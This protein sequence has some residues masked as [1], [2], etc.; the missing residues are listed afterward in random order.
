MKFGLCWDGWLSGCD[1]LVYGGQSLLIGGLS[2]TLLID[3]RC[4]KGGSSL[5][6]LM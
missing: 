4:L 1:L 5:I 2:W 6:V 3:G